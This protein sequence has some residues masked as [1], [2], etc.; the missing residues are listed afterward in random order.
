VVG[1]AGV[2]LIDSKRYT[3][4]VW[5]GP[6]G[7]VWHN[8]SPMDR[9]LRSL[10]IQCAAIAELLGVPVRPLMCVHGARVDVAGLAAGEVEILPARRLLGVL[11]RAPAQLG[12]AEVAG[13]VAHAHT[14]LRPA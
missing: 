1:P 8:Q 7:R 6:D 4:R 12:Q 10:R 11:G 2:V 5:Q 14:M 9:P 13:L 3:G